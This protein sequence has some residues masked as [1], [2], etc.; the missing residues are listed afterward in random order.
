LAVASAVNVRISSGFMG[1]VLILLVGLMLGV[2][3]LSISTAL[4]FG[5]RDHGTFFSLLSFI[6]LPIIF[7]SSAFAPLSSMPS[8][9]QSASKFNPLTYAIDG[10]INL[11]PLWVRRAAVVVYILDSFSV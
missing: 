3:I 2:G 7:V 1:V 5:M 9:L 4:A 6:S 10:V 11:N 8:W